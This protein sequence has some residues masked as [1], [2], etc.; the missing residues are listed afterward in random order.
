MEKAASKR[1]LG[2]VNKANEI[3]ARFLSDHESGLVSR[4]SSAQQT[5]RSPACC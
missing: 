4:C 3:Q 2:S 5:Q 1:K